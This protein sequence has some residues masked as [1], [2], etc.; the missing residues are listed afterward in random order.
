M[1]ISSSRGNQKGV[2]IGFVKTFIYFVRHGEV[3]NPR[4]IWY[5][6]IPGVSLSNI[7]K[8]EIQQTAEFL[9]DKEIDIIFSSNLLRTKQS[10]EIVQKK[11]DLPEI[12]FSSDLLEVK[13]SFQ[14]QSFDIAR[15]I[16]YDIFASDHSEFTGET[17]E[18]VSSRMGKF[19]A[20]ISEKN[21]G[22]NIVAVSHG[23]PI[24][25]ISV[26]AQGL[27][28]VNES[29]R[30]NDGTYIKTGEVFLTIV[31]DGKLIST[32]SVFRPQL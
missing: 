9:S 19:A 26:L 20:E 27:P 1:V 12:I 32:E 31:E 13:S 3:S 17:I 24:M 14:G 11:L 6:R 28:I 18:N 30:P 15:S 2:I 22:Q 8:K 29:I 10:A 7:G 5:G 23:D 4:D 25:L 16:N 21:N